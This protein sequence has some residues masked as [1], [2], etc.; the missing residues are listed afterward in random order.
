MIPNLRE[1]TKMFKMKLD[2]WK[3]YWAY[4]EVGI[5]LDAFVAVGLYLYRNMLTQE[6]MKIF[7]ETYGNGFIRSL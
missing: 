7:A 5:V 4:V 1:I 2:Y 6:I 3:S